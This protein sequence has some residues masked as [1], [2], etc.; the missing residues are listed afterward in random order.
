MGIWDFLLHLI[1]NMNVF[2]AVDE[3]KKLGVWAKSTTGREVMMSSMN[4]GA[5]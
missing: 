4:G 2:M 5:W 3:K 1:T